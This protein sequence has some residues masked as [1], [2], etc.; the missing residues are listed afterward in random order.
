LEVAVV[1]RGKQPLQVPL[2]EVVGEV[3]AA[4]H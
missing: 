3:L 2:V 1:V 4:L